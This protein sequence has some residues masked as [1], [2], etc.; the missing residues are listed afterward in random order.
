VLLAVGLVATLSIKTFVAASVLR[1]NGSEIAIA[2][3]EAM[4][5]QGFQVAGLSN[6][7]GRAAAMVQRDNCL[8]YLVPVSEQG[9]HQETVRT[10]LVEGQKLYF[11]FNNRL[12][13][14]DQP[15][16]EPL[17][18]FYTSFA[19]AHGGLGSGYRPV[20]AVVSSSGCNVSAVD[21]NILKPVPYVRVKIVSH[22]E[23]E[24]Y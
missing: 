10:G 18:G 21:W 1:P 17:L 5:L 8:L 12:Y 2:M 23:S 19:L 24:D 3:A 7:A 9:W 6:F 16:W 20:V 11:L 22:R 15:R 13:E 14:R 4:S